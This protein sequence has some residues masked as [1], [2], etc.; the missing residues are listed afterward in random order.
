M[1]SATG[2]ARFGLAFKVCDA[3]IA[4]TFKSDTIVHIIQIGL[5][6]KDKQ[7]LRL[8][9]LNLPL[10]PCGRGGPKGRRGGR[11]ALVALRLYLVRGISARKRAPHPH[12]SPPP[13]RGRGLRVAASE[14]GAIG[15]HKAGLPHCAWVGKG[16][17]ERRNQSGG[18]RGAPQIFLAISKRDT[19]LA[20]IVSSFQ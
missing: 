4:S 9:A 15:G 7:P 2:M 14:D 20:A 13:S 6:M 11:T 17:C 19:P 8:F 12:P 16:D 18:G 5:I 1:N 10:S 3:I